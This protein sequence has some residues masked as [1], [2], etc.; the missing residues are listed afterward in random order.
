MSQDIQ[1][2]KLPSTLATLRDLRRLINEV[3]R[4]DSLLISS[5]IQERTG[6]QTGDDVVM[7][8]QL[9]D[10]ME[11]NELELGDSQARTALI[12]QLRQLK[13]AVSTIHVTFA[14]TVG[15][16]EL[17]KLVDW[18]RQA[19]HPQIVLEIGLAPELIG[20]A[21]VRTTNKVFDFSVRAQLASGRQIIQKDLEA[22]S[23]AV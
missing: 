22:L 6:H 7:S 13:D 23:G 5:D 20:G 16:E 12:N 2:F 3:E 10:F 15:Q 14:D 18:A 21:Y 4:I 19:V 1:A 8:D 17:A 9:R 11:I